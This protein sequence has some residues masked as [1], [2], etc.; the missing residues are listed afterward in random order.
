MSRH[1]SHRSGPPR[2]AGRYLVGAALWVALVV[3]VA[4]VAWVAI[5]S[6]GHSVTSGSLVAE[7]GQDG[8]TGPGTSTTASSPA[9]GSGSQ[10]AGSTSTPRT[11]DQAPTRS[12]VGSPAVP[13]ATGS[14]ANVATR[15]FRVAAG[16]VTASCSG[17]A[18]QLIS[19]APANG[20]SM[21]VEKS[22]PAEVRVEFE[23]GEAKVRV[24]AQCAGGSP[25]FTQKQDDGGGGGS[26]SSSSG[27]DD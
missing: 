14:T 21:S 23:A 22:G 19:A 16:R 7:S 20:W 25:A 12:E 6:A 26:G 27:S 3:F 9:G 24:S 5:S 13:T 4:G 18:I 8:A 10:P 15:T 1:K 2:G 11:E 17:S